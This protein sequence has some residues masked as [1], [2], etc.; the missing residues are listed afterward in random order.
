[1]T[2]LKSSGKLA[3]IWENPDS[4]ET[5][6][7]IGYHLEKSGSFWKCWDSFK[8]VSVIRAKIFRTRKNFPCSNATLLP[9]FLRL[10]VEVLSY[11]LL[12]W[13]QHRWGIKML[14]T[15]TK[16]HSAF[17]ILWEKNHQISIT[18]RWRRGVKYGEYWSGG[19]FV[20]FRLWRVGLFD[21]KSGSGR[22][23]P[24]SSGFVFGF[25]YRAY[26]GLKANSLVI[27][28]NSI[29]CKGTE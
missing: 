29:L 25:G 28:C 1:M 2:V 15:P 4:F 16:L 19:L 8:G 3:F 24:K 18:W 22:V 17:H 10:W 12:C 11:H 14:L 23:W 20:P 5:I 6:R 21:F 9:R 7:K 27:L 13:L 26:Y